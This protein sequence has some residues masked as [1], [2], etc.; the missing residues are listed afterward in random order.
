MTGADPS[1][2][3]ALARGLAAGAAGT[4]AMT[5]A[6]TAYYRVTGGEPSDTPAQVGRRIVEGVLRREVPDE[7]MPLLN[8][9]MHWLYGTSWGGLY[10]IVA[11]HRG[12]GPGGGMAL[13][14]VVWAT[15]VVELPALGVAPPVWEYDPATLA[16]DVGFHAVYG[17]TVSVAHAALAPS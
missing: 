14:A 7:R 10:G 5:A 11:G 1:P 16:S 12:R 8:Q 15:S 9:L 17:I 4:A 3:A 2:A 6:Q 13:A